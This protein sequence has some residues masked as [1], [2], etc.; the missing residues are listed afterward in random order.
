VR[1]RWMDG[2]AWGDTG[3]VRGESRWGAGDGSVVPVSH[4]DH[5]MTCAEVQKHRE[6]GLKDAFPPP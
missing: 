6:P 2:D 1:A 3:E 5:G 4:R